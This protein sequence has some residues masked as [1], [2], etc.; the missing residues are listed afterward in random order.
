MNTMS[1]I[2]IFSCMKNLM[3]MYLIGFCLNPSHHYCARDCILLL[4]SYFYELNYFAI[5]SFCPFHSHKSWRFRRWVVTS[6]QI[7]FRPSLSADRSV[8]GA[9]AL[10]SCNVMRCNFYKTPWSAINHIQKKRKK[11]FC[12][13]SYNF[14]GYKSI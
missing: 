11:I 5:S 3:P 1:T 9:L 8:V 10:S 6:T 4:W 14:L 2:S 7:T 13:L 12:T